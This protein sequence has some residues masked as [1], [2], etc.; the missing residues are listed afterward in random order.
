MQGN[1]II[2]RFYSVHEMA[3]YLG[4]SDDA[5]RSWVK[6]GYIPFSKLGRAVRFDIH[7]IDSWLKHREVKQ[8][9]GIHLDF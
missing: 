8:S 9:N 7:K 3:V 6:S 1:S 4:L 5:I 2:K